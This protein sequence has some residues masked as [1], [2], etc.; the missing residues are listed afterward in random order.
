[1]NKALARELSKHAGIKWGHRIGATLI[2]L[3]VVVIGLSLHGFTG[4]D[5]DTLF[6]LGKRM[7]NLGLLAYS[8][9]GIWTVGRS[10]EVE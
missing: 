8:F 5:P 1:M 9:I 10:K 3:G 7:L 6:D 2:L 4:I